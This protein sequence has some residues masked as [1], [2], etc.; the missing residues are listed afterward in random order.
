MTEITRKTSY[1]ECQ[2]ILADPQSSEND[3]RLAS[4]RM[5]SIKAWLKS[6]E[7]TT[8][9]SEGSTFKKSEV[10]GQIKLEQ[11]TLPKDTLDEIE[12]ETNEILQTQLARIFFI[13]QALNKRGIFPS[14]PFVGMLYNQQMESLRA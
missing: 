9:P 8:K 6:K 13:E 1:K 4:E 7:G 12:K 5:D 11:I 2:V 10:R 14:G 3:K